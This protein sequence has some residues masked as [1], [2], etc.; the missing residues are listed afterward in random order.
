KRPTVV[1]DWSDDGRYLLVTCFPEAGGAQIATIDL[2]T[3]EFRVLRTTDPQGPRGSFFSPDGRFVAFD[4]RAAKDSRARDIF[5]M[6]I[7]DGAETP[8][9]VTPDKEQLLG[10]LPDG[11]GILFHRIADDSRAI[12]KLPLREG[13]ALGPPELVKDDVWQMTGFGFADD[14]YVY[15][16]TVSN[17]QVHTA[18][19]DI[20]GSRVLGGLEPVSEVS[21]PETGGAGWLP[22]GKRYAYMELDAGETYVVVRSI[23]GETLQE[24]LVPL[25]VGR[26]PRPLRWSEVG[27]LVFGED[28][29]GREGIHEISLETEEMSL[30]SET[31]LHTGFAAL[32][33]NVSEDGTR[34]RYL[35]R[36]ALVEQDLRTGV[37]H[38]LVAVRRAP[39]SFS[40][41]RSGS[42]PTR[43]SPD[44][45]MIAYAAFG[46]QGPFTNAVADGWAIEVE[47]WTDG[48]VRSSAA[49]LSW[50]HWWSV[51]WS[52]DNRYV[53]FSGVR[54]VG[55]PARL[56]RFSLEDGSIED[57]E[58]V[59]SFDWAES[60]WF[61]FSPDGQ[62]IA[63]DAGENRS[64]IWRMTFDTE[65]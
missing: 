65:G 37:E 19:I 42:R 14:S 27:L 51:I 46:P 63:I 36:G 13:R 34:I 17:K 35:K 52:P 62:Y 25:D 59:P 26:S 24:F 11:S 3:D 44:G 9:I 7:D 38:E 32:P 10:W 53:F 30:V 60:T 49:E 29:E 64:E 47:S 20:D 41:G 61:S 54:E 6:D 18:R 33:P 45:S 21:G 40:G 43:I 16:V 15:G 12:W 55:D 23:N 56:M 2:T 50:V 48:E 1:E 22:D 28:G 58:G 39:I 8:L 31:S 57:V 4:L 5:I